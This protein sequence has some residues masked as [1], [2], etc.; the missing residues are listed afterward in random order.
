MAATNPIGDPPPLLACSGWIGL[1]EDSTD[2]GRDQL[3]GGLGH[4]GQGVA[5]EVDATAL[6]TRP[7][8]Y[9][10]NRGLEPLMATRDHQLHPP[11]AP[12]DQP[13]P[14]ATPKRPVFPRPHLHTH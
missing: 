11:E 3:G 7:M 5:H 2:G 4:H 8:Q 10:P 12:P 14:P 13:P 6:P 1:R 9:R